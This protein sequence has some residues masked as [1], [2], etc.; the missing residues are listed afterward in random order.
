MPVTTFVT[1][2]VAVMLGGAVTVFAIAEW[3]LVTI[4]PV[5]ISVALL[6]RWALAHVTLDDQR[7]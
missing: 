3:G 7:S 2:I 1:L 5:L 6:A 4:L